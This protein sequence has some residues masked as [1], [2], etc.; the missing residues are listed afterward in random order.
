MILIQ[1]REKHHVI[2]ISQDCEK[3][4]CDDAAVSQYYGPHHGWMDG[5]MDDMRF[6]VLFNCNLV[7]SGR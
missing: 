5:L 2:N 4:F 3:I 7:M 1:L 6:Y